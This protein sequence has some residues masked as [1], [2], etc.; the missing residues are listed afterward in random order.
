[1]PLV[2]GISQQYGWRPI[3]DTE[4]Y[5]HTY[6][7]G[8]PMDTHTNLGPCHP[9]GRTIS[10]HSPSSSPLSSESK[11]PTNDH[12]NDHSTSLASPSSDE[13]SSSSSSSASATNNSKETD[14][15]SYALDSTSE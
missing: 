6:L 1:M 2:L 12:G 9:D 7:H 15:L 13:S 4:N 8:N 11:E 10:H 5:T 14:H 3:A